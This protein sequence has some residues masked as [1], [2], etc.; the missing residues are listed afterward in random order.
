[1]E[2]PAQNSHRHLAGSAAYWCGAQVLPE[3]IAAD[4]VERQVD[5]PALV[6][7]R[8]RN[9]ATESCPGNC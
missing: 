4:P 3:I 1:M 5:A 2:K 7:A 9:A 8:A 6:G